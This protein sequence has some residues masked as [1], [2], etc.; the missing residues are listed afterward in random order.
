VKGV[1]EKNKGGEEEAKNQG[2]ATYNYGFTNDDYEEISDP[3]DAPKINPGDVIIDIPDMDDDEVQPPTKTA[4][5]GKN[6]AKPKKGKPKKGK[7]KPVKHNPNEP[8]KGA[9]ETAN[10]KNN[11]NNNNLNNIISL[12]GNGNDTWNDI[13]GTLLPRPKPEITKSSGSN[14][15]QF[16]NSGNF[17]LAQDASPAQ[18]PALLQGVPREVVRVFATR[19]GKPNPSS[20][21]PGLLPVKWSSGEGLQSAGRKFPMEVPLFSLKDM[22]GTSRPSSKFSCANLICTNTASE[23]KP[24]KLCAKCNMAAYCSRECQVED[25]A[26]RH[27]QT[28][29]PNAAEE[30]RKTFAAQKFWSTS[31]MR[32]MI[33]L[34]WY[35]RYGK[36][37][38]VMMCKDFLAFHEDDPNGRDLYLFYMPMADLMSDECPIP[39]L[40]KCQA[41]FA[42]SFVN[43]D[44]DTQTIASA[45][46]DST[47]FV[48]PQ[49]DE[50]KTLQLK[51]HKRSCKEHDLQKV[52]AIAVDAHNQAI[53]YTFH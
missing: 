29:K 52:D 44:S 12:T 22:F 39:A 37:V 19:F 32:H 13:L 47:G 21:Y 27:K 34:H 10:A 33:Y 49:I 41:E 42:K 38:I 50:V 2:E 18:P 20:D 3:I 9:R 17:T 23:D 6:H 11:I 5:N 31:S 28:C 48:T 43:H 40:K 7:S 15:L 8:E 35:A 26:K 1:E 36:G 25:W 14:T 30:S 16:D 4:Q 51:L 45:A 53:L 24:F 46:V